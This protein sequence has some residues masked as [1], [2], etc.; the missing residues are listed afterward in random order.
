MIYSRDGTRLYSPRDLVAYLEG[1]FAAWCERMQIERGRACHERSEWAGGAG[2]AEIEWVTP[3][4][5]DPELELVARMGDEHEQRYLTSLRA[6]VP[7]IVELTRE[8]PDL[9][10]L[11]A[12]RTGA[13]AIYQAH[14]VDTDWHGYADFLIRSVGVSTFGDYLYVPWDTKLAKSAKPYFLIQ[15]CAYAELLEK[16]QGVRPSVIVF[17]LGDG[18]ER[19][20][21]T[22]D[23]YYYYLQLKNR[24]LGFQTDWVKSPNPDPSLDKSW[25][26]WTSWAE[27][28]LA[29][30]DH[31]SQE[32]GISRS[33]VARLEE[34]GI[35]CFTALAASTL[36]HVPHMTDQVLDKL[37][38]QARLQKQSLDQRRPSWEPRPAM[39]DEPRCGLG[40]LPRPSS[41]DVFFDMEGFP[42]IEGGME[43]L[44]G[45]VTLTDG[46]PRFQDW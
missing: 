28:L 17:V 3:D 2:S 42:Y 18:T 32:A 25:G 29:Q 46:K 8:S 1:D 44:W 26:R 19:R 40:L 30:S 22:D 15:L 36:S 24:F 38:A 33:Q 5:K 20:F 16:I 6:R 23:F 43:Y 31:L 14:L 21:K 35:T 9:D 13:L 41:N 34:A 12:M 7:T 39:P 45:V 27:K 4:E 10:T 37:Q 11:T